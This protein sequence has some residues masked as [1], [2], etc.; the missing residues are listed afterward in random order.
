MA[1]TDD[2]EVKIV[3][4]N[5]PADISNKIVAFWA[6]QN[7]LTDPNL[8]KKRLRTI[9]S[10]ALLNEKVVAVYTA[11]VATYF[12]DD[13]KFFL[14]RASTAR[15]Y[16]KTGLA[17]KLGS[18]TYS[19]LENWSKENPAARIKGCMAVL[20]TDRFN[21]RFNNP[22]PGDGDNFVGFNKKNQPIFVRWFSHARLR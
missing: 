4:Q 11:G 5:C 8:I 21:D 10:V 22:N 3:W 2:I 20:E 6:E 18:P 14:L 15:D 16:R 19:H 12:R 17:F 9:V 1:K 13:F 7:I